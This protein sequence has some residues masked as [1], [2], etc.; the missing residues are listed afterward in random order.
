MRERPL[1]IATCTGKKPVRSHAQFLDYL[2][3]KDPRIQREVL[4]SLMPPNNVVLFVA[5]EGAPRSPSPEPD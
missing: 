5:P 1:A 3:A 2:Q 4:W